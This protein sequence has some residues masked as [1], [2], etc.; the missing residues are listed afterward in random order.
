V[1]TEER[2]T[3]W[4]GEPV[5]VWEAVWGIPALEVWDAIGSTNDRARE[6][7]R[8]GAAPFTTV[9]AERQLRGRGRSGRSWI[10]PAGKGLWLSVVVHE[11]IRDARL[12][13]PLLAGVAVCRAVERVA[14]ELEAR[15]KWPNDVML[16]GRKVCGILCEAAGDAVVVG[17]GINVGQRCEDFP[18]SLQEVATSVE[19]ERGAAV[20][21]SSLAGRALAEL[22][23]LLARPTL[24]LEPPLAD[25]VKLRDALRGRRVAVEGAEGIAVGIDPGGALRVLEDGASEARRL[26][27]GSVRLLDETAAS[28]E[29][30]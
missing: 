18:R 1:T 19:A 2:R 8:E 15:L 24:R 28:P 22:R 12:L 4:E 3:H 11:R 16:R 30:R 14:S 25:E 29:P 26:M 17:V 10:S 27:A 21:R 20:S 6:L 7:A 5:S 13:A 23:G 9:L